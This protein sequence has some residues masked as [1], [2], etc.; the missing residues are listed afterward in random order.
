[1]IPHPPRSTRTG[2]LVPYTAL[3]QSVE[4]GASDDPMKGDALA[5]NDL[6]QFP[7]IVGG[8][9]PV[10]NVDGIKPGELKLSGEI[11]AD[12]YMATV[13]KWNDPVIQ[14]MKRTEERLGGKEW[15]S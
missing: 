11:I 3:V 7:A 14:E 12:I 13:K 9:V 10:V 4:F 5:K 15:F 2:P 1:M 8:T 6:F